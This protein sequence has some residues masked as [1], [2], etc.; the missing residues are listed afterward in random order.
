M[1]LGDDEDGD[2]ILLFG[3]CIVA[4]LVVFGVAIYLL[5]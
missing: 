3:L 1:Y 5:S 4:W 2:P